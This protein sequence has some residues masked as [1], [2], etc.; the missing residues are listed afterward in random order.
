MTAVVQHDSIQQ[1]KTYSFD[2]EENLIVLLFSVIVFET[3]S[4]VISDFKLI[5]SFVARVHSSFTLGLFSPLH[6]WL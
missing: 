5:W 6:T 4:K 2:L 3:E 1:L